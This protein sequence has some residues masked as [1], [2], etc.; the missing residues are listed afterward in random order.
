MKYDELSLLLSDGKKLEFQH[1]KLYFLF[2]G[3]Y[4]QTV[5]FSLGIYLIFV[6]VAEIK[7]VSRNNFKINKFSLTLDL[8]CR[9]NNQTRKKP[10]KNI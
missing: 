2:T 1:E 3:K 6:V 5:N 7:R 10:S 9:Q 4:C 8:F